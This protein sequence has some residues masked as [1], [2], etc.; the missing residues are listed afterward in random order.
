MSSRKLSGP[1]GRRLRSPAA[2]GTPHRVP[3]THARLFLVSAGSVAPAR[4]VLRTV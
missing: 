4:S 1:K 2:A 3:R